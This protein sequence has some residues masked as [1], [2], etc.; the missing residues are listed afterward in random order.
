MNLGRCLV[1]VEEVLRYLKEEDRQKIP[2]DIWEFILRNKDKKYKWEI[3]KSKPL[4]EQKLSTET[5]AILAYINTEFLLD[6]EKKELM[7]KIY[8]LNDK[9]EV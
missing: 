8:F 6:D 5:L 4:K 1:E 2:K 7:K 3:D 9:R